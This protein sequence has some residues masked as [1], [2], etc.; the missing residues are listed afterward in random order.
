VSK[1]SCALTPSK[2]EGPYFVD[3]QLLRSD[4]TVEP[5]GE[6]PQEGIGLKL[7]LVLVRSDG[8]CGPVAGAHV[9]VWHCN[10]LGIYSDA[11]REG[12]SG[13]KF[14]RGCQISD[15]SGEVRFTTI[16]PGWYSGRCVHIHF[17]VRLFDGERHR[18]EFT[19]QLFFH[20]D[21]VDGIM[22]SHQPYASRGKPEVSNDEDGIYGNDGWK[23]TLPLQHV[24][25]DAFDGTIVVGLAGLPPA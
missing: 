17:K 8:D 2:D 12:T 20:Q 16:L 9:D 1:P 21:L 4:I 7:R 13:R 11:V 15:A 3:E 19:S 24:D 6:G 23:L 18:Y 10:A 14:L 25:H 22:T 5:S